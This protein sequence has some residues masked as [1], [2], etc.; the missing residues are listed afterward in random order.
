[1]IGTPRVIVGV[2]ALASVSVCGL[3]STLANLEMVDKVNEQLPKTGQFEQFGW[4]AEKT[5]RLHREYKR[6]YPSGHLSRKVHVFGGL[7]FAS[8]LTCVWSLSF[9]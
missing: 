3:I 6:L 5:L 9:L 4:H 7:M 2:L 8:L 1:M